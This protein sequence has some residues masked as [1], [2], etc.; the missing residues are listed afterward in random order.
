M[1]KEL[2]ELADKFDRNGF[3]QEANIIDNIIKKIAQESPKENSGLESGQSKKD[4]V[5]KIMNDML[6][7]TEGPGTD[8]DRILEIIKSIKDVETWFMLENA[9][10]NNFNGSPTALLNNE[11]GNS[12]EDRYTLRQI[13]NHLNSIF[14]NDKDLRFVNNDLRSEFKDGKLIVDFVKSYK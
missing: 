2:T 8:E 7:A 3:V 4:K 6:Q 11:F 1:L 12:P 10:N 5:E 13:S 14:V 9:F